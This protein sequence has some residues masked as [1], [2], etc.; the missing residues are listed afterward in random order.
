M[1]GVE[2]IVEAHG[3]SPGGL[4]DLGLL[5]ALFQALI[6]DLGLHTVGEIVWHQFPH[7]GGITGLA[8]LSESH[9]TCHTFPEHGSICLNLF[10]CRPRPRWDFEGGLRAYLGA[11]EVSVRDVA[12]DYAAA[13]VGA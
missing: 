10:S 3:C 6:G 1:A 8:L 13:R 11:A 4:R 5:R 12:R 7:T 2:W 9:L